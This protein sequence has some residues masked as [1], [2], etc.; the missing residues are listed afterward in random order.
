MG[1]YK[2]LDMT[3]GEIEAHIRDDLDRMLGPGGFA[4][5]RDIAAITV[6][7]WTHGYT[8]DKNSLFDDEAEFAATAKLARR[9]AGRAAIANSDSLWSPYAHSAIDAAHRAVRE[10][11]PPRDAGGRR[12][13]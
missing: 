9:R 8:Y 10:L 7:R 5:G 11:V 12:G 2:L 3:F 1:R 13:R 4:S 6:N